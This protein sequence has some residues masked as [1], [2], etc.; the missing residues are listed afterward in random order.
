METVILSEGS[1]IEKDKYHVIS[2]IYGILNNDT[3]EN[4]KKTEIESQTYKTNI[5][6]PK[7][8][9]RGINWEF[10]ISRCMLLCIK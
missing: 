8:K 1:Q 5:W 4:I 6:L 2:F 3:D 10:G 9:G 7:G